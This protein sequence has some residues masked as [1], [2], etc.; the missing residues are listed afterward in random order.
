MVY[1]AEGNWS[2]QKSHSTV[3]I[4]KEPP[5]G[6]PE[7]SPGPERSGGPGQPTH[8]FPKAP[9]GRRRSATTGPGCPRVF[10]RS[11]A[12]A[13]VVNVLPPLRG[14]ESF[15][16]STRGRRAWRRSDPGLYAATPSGGRFGKFGNSADWPRL[17]P[18]R[19]MPPGRNPTV[20]TREVPTTEASSARTGFTLSRNPTV[21]TREVP[22]CTARG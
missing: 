18:P 2:L 15:R 8:L 1:Q 5:E 19:P 22:T 11:H 12:A 4:R 9:Q 16:F 21:L 6:A 17:T 14:L 10:R 13:S 20:L 7:C 3:L